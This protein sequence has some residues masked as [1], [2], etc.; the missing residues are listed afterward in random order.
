MEEFHT[1]GWLLCK[2]FMIM[3]KVAVPMMKVQTKRKL[4]QIKIARLQIL[5][6]MSQHLLGRSARLIRNK[7]GRSYDVQLYKE[8]ILG[9]KPTCNECHVEVQRAGSAGASGSAG[10]ARIC[11]KLEVQGAAASEGLRRRLLSR[12]N[13]AEGAKARLDGRVEGEEGAE[14]LQKG[15]VDLERS[16]LAMAG[17]DEGGRVR[18]LL[19]DESRYWAESDRRDGRKTLEAR[20]DL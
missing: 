5:Y 15:N 3:T 4:P 2:Q 9:E 8:G 1:K 17:C 12:E 19:R 20:Q 14:A 7:Y 13:N 10:A 11:R 6:H 16:G 18:L